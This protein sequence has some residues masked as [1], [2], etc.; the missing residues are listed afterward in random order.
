LRLAG[1]GDAAGRFILDPMRAFV[2]TLTRAVRR[3]LSDEEA[4]D[5]VEY[6]YLCVFVALASLVIWQNVV[7]ALGTHY[8]TVNTGVQQLWEPPDP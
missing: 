5:L 3:F 6:A 8:T 4:Q 1:C 7:T 2:G